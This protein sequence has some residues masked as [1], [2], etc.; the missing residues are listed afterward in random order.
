M[1]PQLRIVSLA[2]VLVL[3]AAAAVANIASGSSVRTVHVITGAQHLE[4]LD[5]PPKGKSPGDVYVFDAPVLAANGRTVIGR[6]RGTQTAI[7]KEHGL[8][9]VQGMLTYELGSGNQIVIGGLSAYP[10]SGAGLV[11][12]KSFVRAVL[13]G[14]GKYA[15]AR[16][17]VTSKQVAPGRYDQVFRLSY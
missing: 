8:L 15:G 13:G 6:I 3:V 1:S 16:G 10:L 5:F 7:K 11:R 9:T 4:T 12:G 2:T 17:T 14:T